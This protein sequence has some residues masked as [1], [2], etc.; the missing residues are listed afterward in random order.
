MQIMDFFFFFYKITF[1]GK[2]NIATLGLLGSRIS[3]FALTLSE[4]IYRT[5]K[6][7]FEVWLAYM[8]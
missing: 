6:G 4:Q 7:L 2:C 3:A 5:T 8:P 1:L